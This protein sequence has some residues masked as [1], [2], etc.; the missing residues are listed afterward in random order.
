MDIRSV[1]GQGTTMMIRLPLTLAIVRAL[2]VRVADEMYAVPLAHV[3]ETV[4]LAPEVKLVT[5]PPAA[6]NP[7]QMVA[8]ECSLSG[9]T[10]ISRSPHKLRQPFMTAAL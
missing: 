7:S 6:A 8:A 9:S 2:L 1:P 5:R 10:K 3:S 4:E